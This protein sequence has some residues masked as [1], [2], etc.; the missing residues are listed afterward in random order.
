MSE[1]IGYGLLAEANR[2]ARDEGFAALSVHA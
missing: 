1:V 2:S